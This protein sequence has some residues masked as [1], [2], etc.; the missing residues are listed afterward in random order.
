MFH[1]VE[2]NLTWVDGVNICIP[3]SAGSVAGERETSFLVLSKSS[4][5]MTL[6]SLDLARRESKGS[7]PLLV[8]WVGGGGGGE[9]ADAT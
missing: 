6:Y 5:L 3:P 4:P 8:C 1:L 2:V 9:G 7:L